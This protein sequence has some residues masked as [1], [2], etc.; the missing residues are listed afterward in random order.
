[1]TDLGKFTLANVNS[2]MVH[3]HKNVVDHKCGKSGWYHKTAHLANRKPHGRVRSTNSVPDDSDAVH[4]SN[5]AVN[6]FGQ[7]P[8][9]VHS[10]LIIEFCFRSVLFLQRFRRSR[11]RC[12]LRKLGLYIF[13][14]AS[15]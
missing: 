14:T 11:C 5:H 3:S 1:V 13:H 15:V 2:L 12:R 7:L 6:S 10:F 9:E 8:L 4:V